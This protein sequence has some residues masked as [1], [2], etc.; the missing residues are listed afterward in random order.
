VT[1][2]D[3]P[4]RPIA[5]AFTALTRRL[6]A[7]F[8]PMLRSKAQR[9]ARELTELSTALAGCGLHKEA[10]ELAAI[11]KVWNRMAAGLEETR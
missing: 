10:A 1:A 9:K 5:A 8:R 2:W 3:R 7:P 11:A 6:Q 4:L